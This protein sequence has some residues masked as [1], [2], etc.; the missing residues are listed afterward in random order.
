MI[1]IHLISNPIQMS[2]I[3]LPMMFLLF[4]FVLSLIMSLITIPNILTVSYRKKLFDE[5]DPRKVHKTPV[6]RLGGISFTP[7]ITISMFVTIG[8]W[9]YF[10][11][12]LALSETALVL[13]EFLFLFAGLTL[14]YLIGEVDDLVGVGYRY[15]FIVQLLSASL[16]VLSGNWLSSLGGLFGIYEIPVW[17]GMPLSVLIIVYITNAI[18]LIDGI[19]GLASG[20]CCI[21]LAVLGGMLAV[22]GEYIYALLSLAT[23]GVVIPF[24]FY[25][26]FG[27]VRNGRKLFMGDTGSLTLGYILSFIIIYVGTNCGKYGGLRDFVV[28][29]SAIL[30]PI[31]D[32][33]RVVLHRLRKNRNPFLPDRNHFHHKLLRTG[34]RARFVLLTIIGV[35]V[36]FIV[37]NYVMFPYINVTLL[38]VIDVVL[39]TCMHIFINYRIRLYSKEHPEVSTSCPEKNGGKE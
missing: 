5:P 30:V 20:L 36:F 23:L 7:S 35:V 10:N 2:I 28:A 25:N 24:W 17:I 1:N 15:K 18:N 37:F 39:W 21:A 14:L 8:V 27:N 22:R 9:M 34:M 3:P 38:L 33:L 29:I 31:L 26:V 12:S 13:H 16:I 6:P 19:D 32:V 4:G 11:P